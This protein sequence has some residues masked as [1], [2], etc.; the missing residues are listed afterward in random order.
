MRI[1][2][3]L[4]PADIH[5]FQDLQVG[6]NRSGRFAERP[7]EVQLAYLYRAGVD[8]CIQAQPDVEF[9]DAVWERECFEESLTPILRMTQSSG[10]HDSASLDS[11]PRDNGRKDFPCN[12]ILCTRVKIRSMT[13]SASVGLPTTSCQVSIG[14][15]LVTTVERVSFRSSRTSSRC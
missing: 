7:G 9:E 3:E 8:G 4:H 2:T 13:A 5:A 12:S 10:G 1:V 11:R 6:T 14:N 15:W